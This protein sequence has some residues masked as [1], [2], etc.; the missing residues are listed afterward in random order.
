MEI[1]LIFLTSFALTALAVP[2]TIKL[3]KKYSLV[4]DPAKRPHP[5]HEHQVIIPRAGGLSIY[6]GLILTTALFLPLEKYLAGI[7][8]GITLLLLIGL[9]D[10]K[11]VKFNPYLR[12]LLLFLA[13]VFPVAAGIGISFISNPFFGLANPFFDLSSPIV[14]LDKWVVLLNFFGPHKIVIIADLLAFF[15]IVILTQIIN[16]SKGVDGQMP[17]ITLVAALA[18]GF[19]SLKLFYQGDPYQLNVAKLAFITAGA[20]LGFLIFN[21]YPAKILPAFSGSTI[22][23]FMLATLSI[24]SGAKLATALV[25]LAIPT[26][27]FVY[28][29]WRRIFSGHSPVW[30]DRG[31]LHHRLL[32]LGWSHQKISLFYIFGSVILGGIA[33]LVNTESKMFILLAV[34]FLFIGFVLWIN[35]FGGLSNRQDPA[36]G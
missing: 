33:Q 21:W 32:D 20:S 27:D 26:I 13:S 7:F 4:D 5:A 17:G 19:F 36:N 8:A 30:G 16:W 18:L 28:T 11:I 24:L 29:F 2:A 25:T 35:S 34:A 9:I 31:H 12:L 15:W 10:D 23:A 3:A 6:I 14:Y 1:L 22:L